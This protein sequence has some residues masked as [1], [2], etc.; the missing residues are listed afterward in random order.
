[1]E[2]DLLHQ[3][4]VSCSEVFLRLRLRL[5]FFVVFN[6]IILGFLLGRAW[7]GSKAS[8]RLLLRACI[9]V[10]VDITAVTII[11]FVFVLLS[12]FLLLLGHS[13]SINVRGS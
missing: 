2:Q 5:R 9:E 11:I 13:G 7:H 1:M 12:N 6:V 10:F 4:L 8:D 3:I